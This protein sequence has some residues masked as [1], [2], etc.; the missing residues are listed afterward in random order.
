M[1]VL[2]S[3]TLVISMED[4]EE[5]RN[6]PNDNQYTGLITQGKTKS[7]HAPKALTHA[8]ELIEEHLHVF[9]R[10]SWNL[11]HGEILLYPVKLAHSILSVVMP[12]RDV[13]QIKPLGPTCTFSYKNSKGQYSTSQ[14]VY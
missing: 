4:T 3:R 8:E 2:A 12:P 1:R 6:F 9:I 11:S 10:I 14:F 5:H 7:T 13:L